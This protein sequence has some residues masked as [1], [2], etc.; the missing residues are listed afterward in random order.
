MNPG[1][2]RNTLLPKGWLFAQDERLAVQE[3][4]LRPHL[5][6][7]NLA[8]GLGVATANTDLDTASP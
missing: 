3:L 6:L 5:R 8:F 4:F 7:L 2:L 1:A